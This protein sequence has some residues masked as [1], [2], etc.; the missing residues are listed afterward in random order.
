MDNQA[1]NNL[2]TIMI[3]GAGINQLELIKAAKELGVTSIVIDPQKDPPG[4]KFADYFFQVN[5]K[6]YESTKKIALQH[7]IDGL[8]TGQMEKPMR[9][10]ARLAEDIGLGFHSPRIVEQCLVS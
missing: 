10:M 9:L 4:K 2:K 8:V 7:R 5:G 1:A 6:D 3:F